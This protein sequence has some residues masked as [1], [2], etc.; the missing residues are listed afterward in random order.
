MPVLTKSFLNCIIKHYTTLV[1]QNR[2]V[3]VISLKCES[4]LMMGMII[5]PLKISNL[6]CVACA[7]IVEYVIS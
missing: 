7:Q 2:I 1:K 5:A 4:S 3:A 6:I